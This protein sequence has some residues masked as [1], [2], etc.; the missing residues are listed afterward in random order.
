MILFMLLAPLVAPLIGVVLLSFGWRF[1]FGFLCLYGGIVGVAYFFGVK[2]LRAD[3]ASAPDFPKIFRQYA[4]VINHRLE[5]KKLSIRYALASSLSTATMMIYL[6]NASFLLQTYFG[7][8]TR[9]FPLFFSINVIFFA[10]AQAFSARYLR[11]RDLPQTAN[12]YRLGHALQLLSTAAL[13]ASVLLFD[14]PFWFVLVFLGASLGCIG[15]VGPSGS[16]IYL[17]AFSRLSGSAAALL[18]VSMFLIGSI[19]G[20]ISG[21]FRTG[22]LLPLATAIFGASLMANLLVFSI[23]RAHEA[24]VLEKLGR[25]EIEPL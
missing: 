7:V 17:A 20:A 12:Y 2:E 4:Q 11:N 15:L 5:G 3:R 23:S 13:L 24:E 8:E 25:G 9:M 18:T 6:T 21:L 16:G 10:V 22:D 1:I 14:P 19:I